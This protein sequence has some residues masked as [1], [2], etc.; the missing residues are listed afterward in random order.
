M[1]FARLLLFAVRSS[2]LPLD[3]FES[4]GTHRKHLR[5]PPL[6]QK[7]QLADVKLVIQ[8]SRVTPRDGGELRG[9]C[10]I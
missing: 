5:L 3:G 10:R 8:L 9:S 2:H 7:Y 6:G 4:Q 1:W